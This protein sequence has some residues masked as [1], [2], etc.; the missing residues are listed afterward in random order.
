LDFD[1]LFP[2]LHG[3]YT[4]EAIKRTEQAV[5]DAQAQ[6]KTELRV[7]VGKVS[8][9]VFHVISLHFDFR[10]VILLRGRSDAQNQFFSM[11]TRESTLRI[12]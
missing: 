11:Q 7:I 5:R 8:R 4:Q 12:T 1:I 9:C 6:G 2:D 3:L 10:D